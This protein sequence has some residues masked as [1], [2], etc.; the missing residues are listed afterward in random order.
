LLFFKNFSFIP[1]EAAIRLKIFKIAVP[2]LP[3]YFSFSPK[4]LLATI[5]PCLL[6]G[7]AN[8]IKD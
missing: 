8:G 4:I 5:R 7:P 1:V 2:K 6:A 3:L